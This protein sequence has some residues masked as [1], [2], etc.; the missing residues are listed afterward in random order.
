MFW[1]FA[2]AQGSY[3]TI[4][5]FNISGNIEISE[6]MWAKWNHGAR[7]SIKT[8][9]QDPIISVKAGQTYMFMFT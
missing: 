2:V 9:P 1:A 8:V 7:N 3:F 5:P 4:F 6:L